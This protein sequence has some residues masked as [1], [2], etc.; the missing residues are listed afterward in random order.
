MVKQ[1]IQYLL[2]ESDCI[3]NPYFNEQKKGDN[4]FIS[5]KVYN[6]ITDIFTTEYYYTEYIIWNVMEK[7]L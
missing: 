4:H 2:C 7:K 6:S 5:N 3:I 1:S